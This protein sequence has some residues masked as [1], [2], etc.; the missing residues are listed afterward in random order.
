MA[1]T[2]PRT[3]RKTSTRGKAAPPPAPTPTQ[4]VAEDSRQ[5]P[6]SGGLDARAAGRGG[7]ARGGGASPGSVGRGRGGAGRPACLRIV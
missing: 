2:A 6:G 7:E 5:G 3:T 4:A 1:K